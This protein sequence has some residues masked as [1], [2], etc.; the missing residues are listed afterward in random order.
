[1]FQLPQLKIWY[2]CCQDDE[3]GHTI[4]ILFALT[5]ALPE[6][7]SGPKKTFREWYKQTQAS[8]NLKPATSIQIPEEYL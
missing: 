2:Y 1:M 6:Q 4:Y 3:T 5:L 7:L 8:G